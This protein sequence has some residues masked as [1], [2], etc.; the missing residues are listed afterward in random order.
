MAID[1]KDMV[2][3][4][5]S[6]PEEAQEGK[7]LDA[8]AIKLAEMGY[9]QDMKR[10]FSVWTLLG[11][12]FSLTNSWFGISAAMITGISSGGPVLIIY[13]IIFIALI[14][15]CVGV[16]L[17]ELA[18]AMP[19][20]GGQYFWAN[21]LAPKNYAN[22]ASYLTG[23]FA[24]AGSIFTSASVALSIGAAGVGCWQLA[25]PDYE[26]QVG[27]VVA[28]YQVFNAF[29]F[30]F[31]CYGRVLPKVATVTLY[32]SLVSF[33][34]ILITVPARAPTHQTAKFVFANFVN[35][36]GWKSN[37]IA[38]I[39][40]LINTNWPFACLDCATH[41]AE[42]VAQ[43]ER[44][45]PI[46][47]LGTVAIGFCTS[48]TYCV[49]MFFSMNNLDNLFST[50]TEVPILELFYQALGNKA[51]AIVLES[52]ILAT[53]IG[54][55]IASHTWQSRLCWSFARDRGLPFHKFLSHVHPKL[56]V[57]LQAHAVSCL[58]VAAV[59]FLYWA[60]YT[61]FNSM[62]TACIVLLYISYAIPVICLLIRGRNNIAHGPFWM[63]PIGL[64]C[65]IV[66]LAWTLFTLV[67]FSFPSVKPVTAGTMNY[68]SAVYGV[69]VVI[70][71][72]DWVV[73]GRRKYRSQA[74]RHEEIEQVHQEI[75][76]AHHGSS[77]RPGTSTA[78][79]SS[80]APIYR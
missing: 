1:D 56:D 18:S 7:L 58:I 55:L 33:I 3:G 65:N 31:N 2:I 62:V 23:W 43:P 25:H 10:N 72:A 14:S 8:D 13:G 47:I 68:V 12:G 32:T 35:N 45:I 48:W 5:A 40:G 21:E 15:I 77:S 61:A 73:R 6:S 46:S 16:T 41:M 49:S 76:A 59:G 42:E 39:V 50:P 66:L 80:A 52:L 20:A 4:G 38:F 19:N 69:V 11:V 27:H 60:S 30:V 22:F 24:W 34:V 51:G 28:S 44:M 70:I 63:G 26:I 64:F 75:A 74:A 54:C 37:G 36:T 78:V 53:G 57:P 71:I 67:M 29:S 79:D 9:R 17:S